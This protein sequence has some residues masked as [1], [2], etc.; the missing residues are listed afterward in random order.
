MQ[1]PALKH[2]HSFFRADISFRTAITAVVALGLLSLGGC[3]TVQKDPVLPEIPLLPPAALGQHLQLT[4]SVTLAIDPHSKVQTEQLAR[5]EDQP[6]TLLAV[7]SV[8]EQGLNFAGLTPAGQV[9]MTLQYDGE[10]FSE[11]YSPLLY[12][13]TADAVK[14]IPGREILAQLQLCYWP[15]PVIEQ[16]LEN[17]PWR[18]ITTEHGRALYLA[19]QIVLDIRL[20][21][22]ALPPVALSA[23]STATNNKPS[24]LNEHIEITNTIMRN[25]LTITTLARAVLP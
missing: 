16:H 24:G 6:L 7:W 15:L 4:Q 5:L 8:D 3:S 11:S 22:I 20:S 17:S 9:L 14:D 12:L 23:N 13:S 2:P 1:T 21:P 25:K 19:E 10:R 18:I